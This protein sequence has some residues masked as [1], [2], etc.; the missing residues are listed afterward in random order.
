[1]HHY[2]KVDPPTQPRS[3]VNP[4]RTHKNTQPPAPKMVLKRSI[5]QHRL[6]KSETQPSAWTDMPCKSSAHTLRRPVSRAPTSQPPN[7][8]QPQSAL[9]PQ[10]FAYHDRLP[11][12]DIIR[13]HSGAYACS[14]STAVFQTRCA[15]IVAQLGGVIMDGLASR[16]TAQCARFPCLTKPWA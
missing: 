4:G 13:F 10:R 3:T 2:T 14:A 11:V 9:Q 6:D 1:M 5:N 16:V 15:W 8:H 12:C 7:Q